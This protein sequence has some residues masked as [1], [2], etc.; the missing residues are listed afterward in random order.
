MRV[1]FFHRNT[2]YDEFIFYHDG[3][4][5][6]RDNIKAGMATLHPRGIHH[7]P[8]PKA[9]LN[10]K[11][12]THTDESAVMLDGLNPIHVLPAGERVEWKEYW[13]S[14]SGEIVGSSL[15]AVSRVDRTHQR[16]ALHA[17]ARILRPRGLSALLSDEPERFWDEL[18]REMRCRVV[19]ALPASAGCQPRTGVDAVVHRRAPQHRPQLPGPL[20]RCDARR[21]HLGR[22]KRRRP[23]ASRFASCTTEANRVANGL[24]AL[25]LQPGD[26]VALC[27]PMLPEILSILY[28]C[29]KAG[30]TV[31]PIFAGF[32]AG[33]IATRIED[34]GARVVFTAGSLTRRGKRIPLAEKM[35]P[36]DHPN[37]R[38]RPL[39]GGVPAKDVPRLSRHCLARF[40][41]PG[42]HPLHLRHDRQ[43]ERRGAHACRMPGAD[44][45]RD[46]AGFRPP[47]RRPLLLALRYRLD[48]GSVD[49]HRAT[50]CSAARFSCTTARPIFRTP[51]ACGR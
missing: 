45:Q 51:R 14:W 3:D 34:S 17:A 39:M 47:A 40:G 25:G 1:P 29:F 13:T 35:P 20:G 24:V 49:H 50:T 8:H 21:L 33:A 46:L 41:A 37:Q 4:F 19:R 6:S 31:V 48:D 44:G 43:A 22:R 27:M 10:Q 28:G 38:R 16:L 12:K 7:G 30:L 5:F 26:R 23:A 11:K 18:M 32:G 2:D 42:L 15:E 9:L 36:R